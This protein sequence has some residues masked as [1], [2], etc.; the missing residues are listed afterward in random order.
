MN[1]PDCHW[2]PEDLLRYAEDNEIELWAGGGGEGSGQSRLSLS[3][4]NILV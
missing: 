4:L 1:T 3:R 2:L